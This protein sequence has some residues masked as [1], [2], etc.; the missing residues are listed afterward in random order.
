MHQR[1]SL[2]SDAECNQL[3]EKL[4]RSWY[5]RAVST[6]EPVPCIS[7]FHLDGVAAAT[8]S[9]EEGATRKLSETTG[10]EEYEVEVVRI[11]GM[12]DFFLECALSGYAGV[13]LD[14]TYAISFCNRIT[15]MDRRMPTVMRMRLPDSG[16]VIEGF[17][18]GRLGVVRIERG[19]IVSW[20]DYERI[21]KASRRYVLDGAPLPESIEAHTIIDESENFVVFGNGAEFLGPY[22]SDMGAVPV[23]SDEMWASY[24]AQVEGILDSS[25]KQIS[26]CKYSIAGV[27]LHELLE[28]VGENFGPGLDIG[29]NSRCH[30]FRQGWF[31]KH[32]DGWMLETISGVWELDSTELKARPDIQPI[33]ADM[34]MKGDSALV[35]SGVSSEVRTPF[36]RITRSDTS[37]MSEEDATAIID[38]QL[39]KT[40]QPE[41]LE[42]DT[43][44]PGDA[45][46]VDA[47][48]KITGDNVAW[49][50]FGDG[51][52]ELYFLVFPD[53]IAAAAY[54]IHEVLPHDESVR[55][56]GYVLCHGGGS[57][58]TQDEEK[59]AR[60]SE[61]VVIAIRKTL[62]DALVNGYRPEHAL[63]LLRLMRDATVTFEVTEI[64]YVADFLFYGMGDGSELWDRVDSEEK[65]S[66]KRIRKLK[67]V[68]KKITEGIN[69][70][71]EFESRLRKSL[72]LAYEKLTPESRIIAASAVEEFE[73]V[74][75]RAG[76]DYAGISMKV[77]KLVERELKNRVFRPWRELMRSDLGRD[78][79]KRLE[80]QVRIPPVDRTEEALINWLRKQSKLELGGMRFCL[81][82]A[83]LTNPEKPLQQLLSTY[84]HSLH[85]G[86]ALASADFES[87]LNDISTKYRNGGVHE[88]IVS[89]EVC[90]QAVDL[91]LF[92][93]HPLLKI[94]VEATEN[95]HAS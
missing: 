34:G 7:P 59:E 32:A 58:G 41:G 13:V 83:L 27:D 77:S 94:I 21:D 38:I 75:L 30:R 82:G 43:P 14:D 31:F 28:E 20:I 26:N 90:K 69:L 92:G 33:K 16:D 87:I 71:P 6:H 4:S 46:V 51:Q 76:Y 45:F 60:I 86:E 72:G 89:F 12:W 85:E 64:G 81:R 22:I 88:H 48:D 10:H 9:S 29:L 39:S 54:I 73:N 19:T 2:D 3:V 67:A 68:K 65:G 40:Y 80:E 47:F 50:T 17:Y 42:E 23:F 93:E 8:F 74:G 52:S 57:A 15:D 78:G 95:G 61:N 70:V 49:S 63:H 5:L 44:L 79:L 36:K 84:L 55:T 18:F 11:G 91:I 24:F 53:I 56:N 1:I 62:V 66:E 35:T 25:G 37:P